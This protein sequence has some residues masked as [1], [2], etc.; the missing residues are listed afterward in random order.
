MISNSYHLSHVLKCFRIE[1]LLIYIY[2]NLSISLTTSFDWLIR[3]NQICS[4]TTQLLRSK[5]QICFRMTNDL[6]KQ[7][8]ILDII[9][10]MFRA[11]LSTSIYDLVLL[12]VCHFHHH[13]HRHQ[14]F[15]QIWPLSRY[16]CL[17][18]GSLHP[19]ILQLILVSI[20]LFLLFLKNC[21]KHGWLLSEFVRSKICQSQPWATKRAD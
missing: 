18:L 15:P 6:P 2:H 4:W 12:D 17:Y 16:S 10:S 20:G 21:L 11:I 3:Q 9:I 1:R 8:W 19:R 13:P 7:A 14:S 5:H